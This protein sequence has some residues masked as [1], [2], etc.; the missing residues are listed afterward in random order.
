MK[1]ALTRVYGRPEVMTV[2]EV[3][4]V[5]AGPGQIL[6]QVNAAPV[7]AGDLRLRAADY[8]SFTK[9]L[10]RAFSG[11]LRPRNP[12]QG[13]NFA[14]TVVNVGPGVT[15]FA[16]GDRVFGSVN[17][18]AYAE[19]IVVQAD[20]AVTHIPDELS[21]TQAAELP[22]GAGTAEFFLRMAAL[23]PGQRVVILGATGGVGRYAVQIA[24]HA[25]AHVTGVVSA[26]GM[27]QAKELGCD[28]VLDYR[29]S[30]WRTEPAFDLVFDTADA[31]SFWQSRSSL[32]VGGTYLTLYISL[33]VLLA[34]LWSRFA[35]RR[36][37]ITVAMPGA[38]DLAELARAAAAKEIRPVT[39]AEFSLDNIREAH[40]MA[41][42]R[43]LGTVIVRPSA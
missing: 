11:L 42:Q 30:D 39:G 32:R 19:H 21:D 14:G 16:L 6:V 25:G 35:P 5:F 34:M 33:Q 23:A 7:T 37:V 20:G 17:H 40:E 4:N 24:K 3:A 12:V 10:G 18:G 8:P 38:E 31:S 28:V 1:A 13:S 27:K 26:R 41:E 43:P 36:A 9:I 29:E 22:Y 15:R 2:E